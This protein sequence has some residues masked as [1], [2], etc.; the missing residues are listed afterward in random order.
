MLF[1]QIPQTFLQHRQAF[2]I[3]DCSFLSLNLL[4]VHKI[5]ERGPEEAPEEAQFDAL[6]EGKLELGRRE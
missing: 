6:K 2:W 5:L 4:I 1:K 3:K